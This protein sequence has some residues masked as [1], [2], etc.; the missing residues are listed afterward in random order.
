M[1]PG[2]NRYAICYDIANDKRRGQIAQLLTDYGV[3]VQFSVFEV[4]GNNRIFDSLIAKINAL[5]D[6]EKDRILVYPLCAACD[7]KVLRIG[8]QEQVPYGNE[9]LLV[10]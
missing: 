6:P 3:R 5:I 8:C 4:V 9:L 1:R 2:Q 10:V 7:S